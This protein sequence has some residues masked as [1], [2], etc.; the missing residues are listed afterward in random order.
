MAE[1]LRYPIGEFTVPR[2]VSQTQ[3][4][5]H[6]DDLSQ[7]PVKLRHVIES[8]SETQLNTP[9]RPGGWRVRQV[10]HHLPDS[11]LNSYT[12]FKL[13][14]TEDNPTIRPYDEAQWAEL[15]DS[16]APVEVSLALLEAL[17]QRWV[18]LL[19]TLAERDW[20]RTFNHPESYETLTLAQNLAYYAWHGEHHLAQITSLREREGWW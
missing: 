19:R 14:L 5:A 1:D 20:Q 10:V 13:A 16:D 17:H 11:H 3:R 7:L 12:R 4:D 2:E 9:Y 15:G 18:I 8:L 6:L